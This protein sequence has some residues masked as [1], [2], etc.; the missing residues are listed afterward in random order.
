MVI[1][2]WETASE[3]N[4]DYFTLERAGEDLN[5]DEVARQNGTGTTKE[6]QA[7]SAIDPYPYAGMSYYRLKQTD[8]DGTSTYSKTKSM[9][10]EGPET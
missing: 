7:Y 5:F 4:N 8:F 1:A 6:P 9:F 10:I 2:T 3:I